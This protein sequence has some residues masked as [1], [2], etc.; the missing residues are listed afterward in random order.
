MSL[1]K[2]MV[3]VIALVV[4][5]VPAVAWSTSYSWS[6][7]DGSSPFSTMGFNSPFGVFGSSLTSPFGSMFGY[8][9]LMSH[10][11]GSY[12]FYSTPPATSYS[13]FGDGIFSGFGDSPGGSLFG[14]KD[15]G[16]PPA[17]AIKET[18][19]GSNLSYNRGFMS[20]PLQYRL[21][22]TDI[23]EILGTQYNGEDAW[24]VRVGQAGVYWDVI[25]DKTGTEIL[26]ASQV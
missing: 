15:Y 10:G 21:D 16:T 5:A 3:S 23:G 2:V 12:P 13:I 11:L 14:Q 24:K 26:K 8:S 1:G 20:I 17:E 9:P 25:L 4:L 6:S 7:T 18:L 22:E 19:V